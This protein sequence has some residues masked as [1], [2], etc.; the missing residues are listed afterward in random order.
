MNDEVELP[1]KENLYLPQ[2]ELLKS[3]RRRRQDMSYV[4]SLVLISKS[5]LEF[6]NLDWLE[7]NEIKLEDWGR[8]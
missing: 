2:E 3:V 7:L 6:H 4:A 8:R 5:D 1:K